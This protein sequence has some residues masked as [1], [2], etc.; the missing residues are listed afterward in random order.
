MILSFLTTLT[1][2]AQF[3]YR[4]LFAPDIWNIGII[5]QPIQSLLQND[6]VGSEVIWMPAPSLGKYAADPF[7]IVTGDAIKIYYE[8]YDYENR[9][10]T[11]SSVNFN[12]NN[13]GTPD[14]VLK[15]DYHVSYPFILETDGSYYCIPESAHNNQL[16]LYSVDL[17]KNVLKFETTLLSNTRARDASIFQ[18]DG[19]WWIFCTLDNG[20]NSCLHIYHSTNLFGPFIPH[21]NNPVKDDLRSARSA[22]TPFIAN[23]N[24]YRP[25]Q[26]CSESYGH[27]VTINK[28]VKLSLDEFE[29][30]IIKTIEPIKDV[31]YPSGIHTL[32]SAGEYTLIDARRSHFVWANFT[33]Q[34]NRKIKKL[35]GIK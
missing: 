5:K 11:I 10:G 8:Q 3:H 12:D 13:W 23:N 15:E 17:K 28:I 19:T 16:S 33:F 4:E 22:G 31:P 29:E 14:N 1:N 25:A 20:P 30:V 18:H 26:D 32:S 9:T 34:L 35:L 6:I 24:L 21:Q 2:K 7:A 27:Q